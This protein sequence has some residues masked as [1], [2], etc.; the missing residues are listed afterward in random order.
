MHKKPD[1][2]WRNPSGTRGISDI[3][4]L[5]FGVSVLTRSNRHIPLQYSNQ[6]EMAFNCLPDAINEP[7]T[8]VD[9]RKF[10]IPGRPG[11]DEFPRFMR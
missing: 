11:G 6:Y 5:K 7:C 9:I 2:I 8:P 4:F 3:V 1:Q 10:V